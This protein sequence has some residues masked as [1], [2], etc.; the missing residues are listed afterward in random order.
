[1]IKA[2]VFALNL[3]A[4]AMSAFSAGMNVFSYPA[5]S[6]VLVAFCLINLGAVMFAF[7]R[8]SA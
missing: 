6:V 4:V 1:M 5:L 3:I 8:A 7:S 2:P